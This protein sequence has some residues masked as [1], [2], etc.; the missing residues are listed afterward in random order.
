MIRQT[1]LRKTIAKYPLTPGKRYRLFVLIAF[2]LTGF[3]PALAQSRA[4]VKKYSALADSLA[5]EYGIPYAVILGVAI[6]ESSSGAGRNVRL[7]NN[8]F[9]IIGKNDL[10][11]TKGIRTRY[12]HY[13][14]ARAS[15]VDFC[16]V[17]KKRKYCKRLKGVKDYKPWIDAISKSGYTEAPATWKN[18]V[19]AAI[20]VNKL[21]ATR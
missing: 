5:K 10:R 14:D 15:F 17:L 7:L 20:R 16:K 2:L 4:Y 1:H 12:K 9:G 6:I 11:K 13:P 3:L 18:R 19:T 21:S 8:H